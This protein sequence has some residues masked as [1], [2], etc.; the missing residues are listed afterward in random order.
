[1]ISRLRASQLV[2][3]GVLAVPEWVVWA[4][5]ERGDWYIFG[6][7]RTQAQLQAV[8]EH[9]LE[10]QDRAVVVRLPGN[11]PWE[12]KVLSCMPGCRA[13]EG[14]GVHKYGCIT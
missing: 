11:P 1:M 14:A 8:K 5:P 12:E 2:R 3:C 6:R 7:A 10:D 4:T 13:N 9:A